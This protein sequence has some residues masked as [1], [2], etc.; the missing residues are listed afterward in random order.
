MESEDKN[1]L[2]L[3][4]ETQIR[5]LQENQDRIE[6]ENDVFQ[7]AYEELTSENALLRK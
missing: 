4:Y 2:Q 7:Q 1:R 5:N 6:K 3:A